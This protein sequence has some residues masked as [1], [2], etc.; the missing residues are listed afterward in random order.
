MTISIIT[1]CYNSARTIR[2]TLTSVGQQDYL[3]IEHIIVDGRSTDETLGI[4]NQFPYIAKILSEKDT[5]IYDAMNKGIRLATGDVIA[6]LNSD[7]VYA[8]NHVL[9]KVMDLFA[10]PKI[11]AVYGDLQYTKAD[12]L[13][14]ISRTWRSGNFSRSKFYYGW[15]PP[16]PAFFIRKKIYN[17]I[18]SF[19]TSLRT[20]ADYE[21]MLRALVKNNYKAA[22]LPEVL[23]K[24]RNGGA[25]NAS[26]KNRINA[27]REDKQAWKLNGIKPYFFTI[28]MKPLRKVFQYLIK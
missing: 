15:M 8:N 26:V 14:K 22:Y 11:D 3:E 25:S 23:V 5:G 18:G 16:H 9:T 20:S 6:I 27:N 7:D 1:A 17:E 21:F 24:M 13:N 10:D 19:N 4:V 28:A 2:D 12:D